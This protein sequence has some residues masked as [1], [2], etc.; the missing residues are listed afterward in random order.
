M[1][2]MRLVVV[3]GGLMGLSIAL[4]AGRAGADVVVLDAPSHAA[5]SFGNAGLIWVQGKGASYP[6]Y[7]CWTRESAERWPTFASRL[8]DETGVDVE[9]ERPGGLALCLDEDEVE[10][11]QSLVSRLS[12]PDVELLEGAEVRRRFPVV[13]PD[14][15][16]ASW[17]ALD[18]AANPLALHRALARAC[19]GC[20]VDLRRPN[21]ALEIVQG[22]VALVDGGAVEADVVVVAAGLSGASLVRPLGLDVALEPV[23]GQVL[24]TERRSPALNVLTPTAR[25]TRAG[26]FLL[27][28]SHET[29]VDN[30]A[31]D[32]SMLAAHAR[33]AVCEF[34]F[35]ADVRVIRSWAAARV[36]TPDGFPIYAQA[37]AAPGVWLAACHSGVTLAAQHCEVVGPAL[38]RGERPSLLADFSTER[39]D[40]QAA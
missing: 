31:P 15:L 40:V 19:R 11:R 34:P 8:F 24:V 32:W 14:V 18:G 3:G 7:A 21:E 23:R 36:V 22:R 39:F 4:G 27:G 2:P 6:P 35:L 33:R 26:S 25:Q 17:C 5:P 10:S 20:G 37:S 28:N 9:Y 12:A 30:P 29:R 38:A 1:K 13:G 16:A